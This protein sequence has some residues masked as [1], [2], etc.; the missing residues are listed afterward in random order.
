MSRAPTTP[1]YEP[2]RDPARG[3]RVMLRSIAV[4]MQINHAPRE[5]L[6]RLRVMAIRV[7]SLIGPTYSPHHE[8]GRSTALGETEIQLQQLLQELPEQLL[9]PVDRSRYLQQALENVLAA[10]SVDDDDEVRNVLSAADDAMN[11]A[12]RVPISNH[13]DAIAWYL[14][15]S[16][17]LRRLYAAR[18]ALHRSEDERSRRYFLRDQE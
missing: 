6:E 15:G 5:V 14:A 12:T 10:N 8:R 9:A 18:E 1:V 3:L 7:G 13:C 4:A 16:Q 2:H 17:A 11:F